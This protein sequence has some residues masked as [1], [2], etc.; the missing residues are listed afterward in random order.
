MASRKITDQVDALLESDHFDKNVRKQLMNLGPAAMEL[1]RQ[2]ATGSHPSGNADLQGRAILTLGECGDRDCIGVLRKALRVP[3]PDVRV[4]VMR[5]MGRLG[6]AE[7]AQAICDIVHDKK[8]SDVERAHG[9]R[10]LAK[11]RT[12]SAREALESLGKQELS[13]YVKGELQ[14]VLKKKKKK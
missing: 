1:L 7:A 12:R 11:I 8:C 4:R 6:G 14:T 5:A 10:S 13:S 2:Y 9:I 3:D